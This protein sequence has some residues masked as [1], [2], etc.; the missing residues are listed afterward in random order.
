MVTMDKCQGSSGSIILYHFSLLQP[1]SKMP[2]SKEA[3]VEQREYCNV[4]AGIE[5]RVSKTTTVQAPVAGHYFGVQRVF[6][7]RH[8]CTHHT[9][10]LCCLPSDGRRT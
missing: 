2:V 9:G 6:T 4:Y 10:P 7:C 5:R 8:H 3:S 1:M